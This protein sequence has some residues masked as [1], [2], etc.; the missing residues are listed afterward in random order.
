M[1]SAGVTP[2]E[3]PYAHLINACAQKYDHQKAEYWFG[4]IMEAG[5]VP[6]IFSNNTLIN[7]FAQNGDLSNS[8]HWFDEMCNGRVKPNLVI[9]NTLINA[10]KENGDID[11]AAHWFGRLEKDSDWEPDIRS[12]TLLMAAYARRGHV[13]GA[14]DISRQLLRETLPPEISN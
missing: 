11:W 10:C 7:A 12:Y 14:E 6:I 2:A 4:K 5:L 13:D 1:L 3:K 8:E 9:Y